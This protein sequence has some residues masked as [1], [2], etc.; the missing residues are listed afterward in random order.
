MEF[1][2]RP[3]TIALQLHQQ[4]ETDYQHQH[5]EA[6]IAACLQALTYKPDWAKAYHTL[7]MAYHSSGDRTQALNCYDRAIELDPNDAYVYAN[8]A[9]LY[10]KQQN[11]QLA[12]AGYQAALQLNLD[13]ATIWRNLAQVQENLGQREAAGESW[14]QAIVREPSWATAEVYTKLGRRLVQQQR[15]DW[16]VEIYR[17][18]IAQYP[19]MAMLH[20]ALGDVLQT[21]GEWQEAIA[22]Y[23]QAI[24][25]KS[26]EP[27]FYRALGKLLQDS[28]L[29]EEA[30]D[31]YRQALHGDTC[32]REYYQ[33]N[34]R[35]N[36]SKLGEALERQSLLDEAIE[37]YTEMIRLA[38][39][40]ALP[41]DRLRYAL[42]NPQQHEKIVAFYRACFQLSTGNAIGSS[43]LYR[44]LGYALSLQNRVKDAIES[45]QQASYY[46]TMCWNEELVQDRWEPEL[47][48]SPDFLI[49]GS[50]KGGTTSLFNYLSKHPQI[51]PTVNKEIDFFS[52]YFDRG[53]QWYLSQFPKISPSL[54]FLVGE[55]SPS[56]LNFPNVPQRAAQFVPKTKLIVLLRNPVDRAISHYHHWVRQFGET[57]TLA[58]AI[59]SEIK[60]L[61]RASA[62]DLIAGKYWKHEGYLSRS[63]Y[64]YD[65]QRW[66]QVFPREQLLVLNSETF[67]E[68]PEHCLNRVFEFLGVASYRIDSYLKFNAGDYHPIDEG[69]RQTLASYFEPHDRKLEQLLDEYHLR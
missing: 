26:D 67:Y 38:P 44:N 2:D 16:A 10:A 58:E 11:W 35:D 68:Q 42:L 69:I 50:H 46:K 39:D 53:E 31:V 4:A 37:C 64:V 57:R 49:I 48:R 25:L 9:S 30:L 51:L 5:F 45:Y 65:L 29:L 34:Y 33:T 7:A 15:L 21:K 62:D 41:Y 63:L 12:Q 18:A 54:N 60:R 52:F 36:F 24:E 28:N 6:A 13:G 1:P 19:Q 32:D 23:R 40:D 3:E 61:D 17:L 56:Y 22:A 14:Y 27:L 8:R 43:L 59:E 47:S 20:G 66:L 55:A